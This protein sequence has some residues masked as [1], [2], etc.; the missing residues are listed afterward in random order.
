M[1]ALAF[2]L[3]VALPIAWLASEFQNQRWIRIVSG[4]AAIAMSFLVAYV[5][6]SFEHLAANDWYGGASKSLI[7]TTIEQIETGETERLLRE[8][9]T[10]QEQFQPTYQN[11]ARY[12]ELIEE[13]K[14][15]LASGSNDTSID[16]SR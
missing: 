7:D 9:K 4:C 6:G 1:L 12:D 14:S 2:F 5:V 3:I 8:L 16:H 13:F 15:R 10:L 11:R